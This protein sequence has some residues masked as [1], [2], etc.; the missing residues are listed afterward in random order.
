M[1]KSSDN[2]VVKVSKSKTPG[3]ARGARGA[4]QPRSTPKAQGAR[5]AKTQ[6]KEELQHQKDKLDLKICK[7]AD[8]VHQLQECVD[9]LKQNMTSTGRVSLTESDR[10][11]FFEKAVDLC[12]DGDKKYQ[13]KEC[14]DELGAA[15]A[16]LHS[17][18]NLQRKP[19]AGMK[20][21]SSKSHV[22]M[23]SRN[24]GNV[25]AG[26]RAQYCLGRWQKWCSTFLKG[27]GRISKH[28]FTRFIPACLYLFVYTLKK[29][30]R[31]LNNNQRKAV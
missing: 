16:T 25:V 6:N 9:E 3:K 23:N 26:A 31:R 10:Y 29:V 8:R 5:N 12:K 20:S 4:P 13:L 7:M 18:E 17:L 21:V 27:F 2:N 28:F 15:Y 19:A 30:K 1:P 14:Y 11:I 24:G 22:K